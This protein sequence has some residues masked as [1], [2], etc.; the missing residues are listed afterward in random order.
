MACPLL[1][2]R[3]SSELKKGDK[4]TLRC[5]MPNVDRTISGRGSKQPTAR[6]R[7][8]PKEWDNMRNDYA[9]DIPISAIDFERYQMGTDS[10]LF[11]RERMQ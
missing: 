3:P 1:G 8:K 10:W 6:N 11:E 9:G 2:R 5:M 7:C 4:Y